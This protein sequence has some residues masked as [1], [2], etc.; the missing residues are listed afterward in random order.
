M[1]QCGDCA[2]H[3]INWCDMLKQKRYVDSCPCF[4]FKAREVKIPNP[5]RHTIPALGGKGILTDEDLEDLGQGCRRVYD[6]MKDGE[7]HNDSEI[8]EAAGSGGEEATEGLRRMRELRASGL[9]ISRR[10]VEASR[11]WEYRIEKPQ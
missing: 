6:L 2:Q 3:R 11:R 5:E 7:W 1:P 9:A 10:R 8:R 4:L